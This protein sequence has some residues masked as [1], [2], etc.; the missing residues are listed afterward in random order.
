MTA[1]QDDDGTGYLARSVENRFLGVSRL[2]GNFTST[3]GGICTQSDQ[4][5]Q[6]FSP[7][8]SRS[9]AGLWFPLARAVLWPRHDAFTGESSDVRFGSVMLA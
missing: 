9:G 3:D 7:P 1:W 2:T 6:R 5:R 4:V 8:G